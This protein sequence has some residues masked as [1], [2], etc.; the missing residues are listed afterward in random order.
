MVKTEVVDENVA[1]SRSAEILVALSAPSDEEFAAAIVSAIAETAAN[2][3]DYTVTVSNRE[4]LIQ[5]ILGDE[6]V[7]SGDLETLNLTS[8][9]VCNEKDAF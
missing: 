2:A 4:A 7:T 6:V 9:L 1:V 5:V 8:C 3:T